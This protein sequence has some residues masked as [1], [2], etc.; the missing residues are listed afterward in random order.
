VSEETAPA[1]DAYILVT[2]QGKK[3]KHELWVNGELWDTRVSERLYQYITLEKI[4]RESLRMH[5]EQ[6][7]K[8]LKRP[9]HLEERKWLR[10]AIALLDSGGDPLLSPEFYASEHYALDKLTYGSWHMH[11]RNAQVSNPACVLVKIVGIKAS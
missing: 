9:W 1:L 4:T 3:N 11:L 2:K 8:R 10:A 7:I 5:Y 6:R